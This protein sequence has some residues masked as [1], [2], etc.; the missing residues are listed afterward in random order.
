M[1]LIS[2]TKRTRLNIIEKKSL[3]IYNK[4]ATLYNITTPATGGSRFIW[5]SPR[6]GL[7]HCSGVLPF[8][9]R[10]RY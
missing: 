2:H 4:G 8:R 3:Q 7:S 1:I 6:L 5:P 10:S 9:L